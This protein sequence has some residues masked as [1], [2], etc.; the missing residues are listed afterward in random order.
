[1]IYEHIN[2]CCCLSLIAFYSPINM[3]DKRNL[4]SLYSDAYGF[5][6]IAF[7]AQFPFTIIHLKS[8][9]SG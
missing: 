9:F 8:D 4:K 3:R 5:T 2:I 1:M 6:G 7:C